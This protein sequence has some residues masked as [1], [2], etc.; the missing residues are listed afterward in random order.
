M[1]NTRAPDGANK[2]YKMELAHA[3]AFFWYPKIPLVPQHAGWLWGGLIDHQIGFPIDNLCVSFCNLEDPDI[4]L[5]TIEEMEAGEK[6]AV[7]IDHMCYG[8]K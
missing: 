6:I 1:I 4:Y 8:G 7:L 2:Q 3:H 5:V